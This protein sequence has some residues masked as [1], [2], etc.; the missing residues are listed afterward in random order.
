MR[1]RDLMV[2]RGIPSRIFVE[3]IDSE[4]A[5]ECELASAYL[6]HSQPG[7]VLVYQFATASQL[8]GWLGSRR[9]TLVVNYHNVTPP[10]LF[11]AW[12]NPLARHQL[13][14]RAELEMLAPRTA[15]AVAVSSHNEM[16]LRAAGFR[17]TSVVPPAAMLPTP[18]APSAAATATV[19][20]PSGGARWLTVGRLAPNKAIQHAL[21]ALL[22]TRAHHDPRA[23]LEIVG[24]TVVP[25]YTS[26]LHRFTADLGL[27]DAVTLVFGI[28]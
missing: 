6:E 1:L 9:E 10:E 2:E 26:A 21:M 7:D 12:D 13:R 15:L 16:E 8:A 11:A 17:V 5:S 28:W 23:T 4:T 22:V 24:Q 18:S 27:R 3:L 20:E 19:G 25:A 14:A